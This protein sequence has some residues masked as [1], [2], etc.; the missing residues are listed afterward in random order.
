MEKT[1]LV[2]VPCQNNQCKTSMIWLWL[3]SQP[4]SFQP[5]DVSTSVPDPFL[6]VTVY[7]LCFT[8]P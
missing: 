2:P 7:S 1:E 4:I 3:I 5:S 8:S 6:E